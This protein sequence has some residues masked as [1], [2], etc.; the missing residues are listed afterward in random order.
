MLWDGARIHFFLHNILD[1]LANLTASRH[2]V[3]G[4]VLK[5]ALLA[6]IEMALLSSQ[7][8]LIR[9]WSAVLENIL[10]V[11][12]SVKLEAATGGEWRASLGRCLASLVHYPGMYLF[13]INH[14]SQI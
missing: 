14:M 11:A 9:P 13:R 7:V 12:D 6:W 10:M 4:L 1:I 8:E 5:S 2:M 3:T